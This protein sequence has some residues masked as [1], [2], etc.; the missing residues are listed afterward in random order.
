[1]ETIGWVSRSR[2]PVGRA[3][4]FPPIDIAEIQIVAGDLFRGKAVGPDTFS[5]EHTITARQ[6][7]PNW[8]ALIQI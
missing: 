4:L 5:P 1:M 7:I 2:F 8:V 3:V 6:Y